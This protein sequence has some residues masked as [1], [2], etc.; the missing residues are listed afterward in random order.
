[1]LT[2][3]AVGQD[4]SRAFSTLRWIPEI[5]GRW[6][7]IA[8]L[9]P[10]RFVPDTGDFH[11]TIE[12]DT[13]NGAYE[14]YFHWIYSGVFHAEML[15]G[16]PI[17]SYQ[18]DA[19]GLVDNHIDYEQSTQSLHVNLTW[20]V[21]GQP[22]GDYVTFVHV[23]ADPTLPPV[24]QQDQ[25]PGGGA[26]PPQNWLPGVL[27]DTITVDLQGVPPGKYQIAVGLYDPHTGERLLPTGAAGEARIFIGEVEIG[28]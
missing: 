5:P 1:M 24:A 19:F 8:T 4:N 9:I 27:R 3:H 6:L 28:R 23:I 7:E 26:L 10:S 11:I 22:Q 13:P 25:R 14:P 21:V 20:E 2:I 18:N 16:Q 15:A 17:A 12:V